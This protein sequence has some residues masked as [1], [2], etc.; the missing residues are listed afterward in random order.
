VCKV[1]KPGYRSNLNATIPSANSA[2]SAAAANKPTAPSKTILQ[3]I[4]V[5]P[6]TAKL[7]KI[8]TGGMKRD[9]S[10]VT[11]DLPA[12]KQQEAAAT[13]DVQ[14]ERG[15]AEKG[16]KEAV[17]IAAGLAKQVAADTPALGV[18]PDQVNS[19]YAKNCG[20]MDIAGTAA[21][22]AGLGS[23]VTALIDGASIAG[24]AQEQASEMKPDEAAALMDEV[25]CRI[26]GQESVHSQTNIM[27]A[28]V[29]PTAMDF[30]GAN[31]D[32]TGITGPELEEL[33]MA[34]FEKLPEVCEMDN[35]LVAL[36]GVR[37]NHLAAEAT[38]EQA[39]LDANGREHVCAM[40]VDAADLQAV[41]VMAGHMNAA[42]DSFGGNVAGSIASM[43]MSQQEQ[44]EVL[45]T[46]ADRPAMERSIGMMGAA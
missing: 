18:L 14:A 25:A 15:V 9:A 36:E 33:L 8:D 29:E 5:Q 19:T 7:S 17:G 27:N 41:T 12:A 40:H 16:F 11:S 43:L 4:G 20:T 1:S 35:M 37:A 2:F 26:N 44:N 24:A 21:A 30:S 46:A 39:G 42:P 22:G 28:F 45:L 10:K 3:K 6:D 13:K 23:N 31:C 32:L 34:D 38:N